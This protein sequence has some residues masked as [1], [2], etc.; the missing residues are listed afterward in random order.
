M[1]NTSVYRDTGTKDRAEGLTEMA[2]RRSTSSASEARATP[3]ERVAM[4]SIAAAVL[5]AYGIP[6]VFQPF[7][8]DHDYGH[9]NA[10]L[11]L[12]G[13]VPYQDFAEHNLPGYFLIHVVG[14]LLFGESTVG[15]RAFDVLWIG[16][17]IWSIFWC[18]RQAGESKWCATLA[19]A[20]YVPLYCSLG[21]WWTAQRDGFVVPLLLTSVTLL[22]RSLKSDRPGAI[23]T[24]AGAFAVLAAW[25]KLPFG[26]LLVLEGISILI[27]H[28]HERA[29]SRSAMAGL[30]GGALLGSSPFLLYL[31]WHGVLGDWFFWCFVFNARHYAGQS[32]PWSL[33][34]NNVFRTGVV[35][36]KI[37]WL[38]VL[39]GAWETFCDRR[40]SRQRL[41]LILYTGV[42]VVVL[43][44]QNKG[45]VLYHQLPLM[46]VLAI[47]TAVGVHSVWNV[48][49]DWYVG[50]WVPRIAL[51]AV[52]LGFAG[53][54]GAE[55][56]KLAAFRAFASGGTKLADYQNAVN[57]NQ[58]VQYEIGRRVRELT[59]PDDRIQIWGFQPTVQRI[60]GRLPCSRFITGVI[61]WLVPEG[62]SLRSAWNREAAAD[63]LRFRPAVIV[64]GE[65]DGDQWRRK[66]PHWPGRPIDDL[67]SLPGIAD[68]IEQEYVEDSK[69]QYCGG[70]ER[71][72]VLRRRDVAEGHATPRGT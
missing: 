66:F 62:S 67:L 29:A 40:V 11:I 13:L 21:F 54:H 32:M 37:V 61:P 2:M 12:R 7:G 69:W 58:R 68:L 52:L 18:L 50:R 5:L 16:F 65:R 19:G 8:W 59:G 60:S 70:Q 22:F 43:A 4:V 45:D 24:A 33:L 26:I 9:V 23:A 17:G 46:A 55:V 57:P 15:F 49:S 47:W 64:V 1:R 39:V 71:V 53:T 27:W 42:A 44:M 51:L 56:L 10:S 31:A 41:P 6:Y 38:L 72:L 36:R 20:L 30:V 34:A 28:R 25:I 48:R 35:F 14:I 3:L 63:I